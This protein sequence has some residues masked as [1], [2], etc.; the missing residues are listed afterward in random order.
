MREEA[1]GA[2]TDLI[3]VMKY[4][5]NP[6]VRSNASFALGDIGTSAVPELIKLLEQDDMNAEV[7]GNAI[8][9][10]GTMQ[11]VAIEAVPQLVKAL[12]HQDEG[13]RN[14][15]AFALGMIGA[16]TKEVISALIEALNTDPDMVVRSAAAG[17]LGEMKLSAKE[18]IP[19]LAEALKNNKDDLIGSIATSSVESLCKSLTSAK[20]VRAIPFLELSRNALLKESTP[21]SKSALESINFTLDYLKVL[22]WARLL[23]YFE[24]YP[25][26]SLVI[27]AYPSLFLIVLLLLWLRPLWLLYANEA[28]VPITDISLPKPLDVI[29]LPVR[30]LLWLG[31]FHYHSRVL[32]AWVRKHLSKAIE[33]FGYTPI[34]SEREIYVPV[35]VVLEKKILSS[36]TATELRPVF[37]GN[38]SHLLI[39]GEGGVGKTSLACELGKWAMKQESSE[40]LC[41]AHFMLPIL[42]EQD[43]E[44]Q[45]ANQE[46]SLLS[47]IQEMLRLLIEETE[48][49]P[50]KLVSH[51]LKRRRVLVIVD[52]M[53]EMNPASRANIIKGISNIPINAAIITSR[54]NENLGDLQPKSIAPLKIRGSKLAIFMETYLERKGK[55]QLSSVPEFHKACFKLSSMV[56]KKDITALLAKLYLDQFIAAQEEAQPGMPT[57]ELPENI[58][59]LM[60]NS[61][62]ILNRRPPSD[63]PLTR[64]VI[65]VAKA[66]AWACLK[67]NL[68]PMPASYRNSLR[69]LRCKEVADE[70]RSLDIPNPYMDEAKRGS[71]INYLDQNLSLIKMSDDGLDH[72]RFTLDPLSEYLASLR[73]ISKY[74]DNQKAWRKFLYKASKQEC[75]PTDVKGFLLALL[76]C[77]VSKGA[78]FNVPDFLAIELANLTEYSGT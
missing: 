28:L 58:P 32:D 13:V 59:D 62:M 67:T 44:A 35:S 73:L 53:S 66:L 63:A 74:R 38:I 37:E 25:Y 40:R 55:R 75:V 16:G 33:R 36:L 46:N 57:H 68:R 24:D 20:D 30:H 6:T 70:L 56:G 31:F 26:L 45:Q 22:W 42:L 15:A 69:A 71:L 14:N 76:D 7:L 64:T 54:T 12:K 48:A 11:A 61:I 2:V 78:E 41:P 29:R 34:V 60:V 23:H 21:E 50:L 18:I 39:F 19:V 17:S 1:K 9:A 77:C 5:S 10:L 49:P 27:I 8:S 65:V 72:I 43:L 52:S 47:K 4:D 3:R 51:L